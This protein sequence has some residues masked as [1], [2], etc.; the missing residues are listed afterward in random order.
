MNR[1]MGGSRPAQL[2]SDLAVP[3]GEY[4]REVLEAQGMSSDK[5][6]A[7]SGISTEEL[8][9]ILDEAAPITASLASR[10]EAATGVPSN[11]WLG[12][13]SEYRVS[14]GKVGPELREVSAHG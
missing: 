8:A 9:A 5:F 6:A 4:L 1:Q 2:H 7:R 3:P 14:S 13:E 11:V 12:L 10:L